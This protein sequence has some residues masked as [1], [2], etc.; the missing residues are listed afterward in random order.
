MKGRHLT[1]YSYFE[2]YLIGYTQSLWRVHSNLICKLNEITDKTNKVFDF[3]LIRIDAGRLPLNKITYFRNLILL[4]DK[5]E[6]VT[7]KNRDRY[8][9]NIRVIAGQILLPKKDQ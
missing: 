9:L 1:R 7:Y 5:I 6:K 4:Y 2:P 8:C 3:G